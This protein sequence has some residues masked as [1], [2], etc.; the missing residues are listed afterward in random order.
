VTFIGYNEIIAL[1]NAMISIPNHQEIGTAGGLATAGRASIAAVCQTVYNTILSNRLLVT[2]P[3]TIVPAV[4][5]AG[6]H[7][8]SVQALLEALKLNTPA[9]WAA[10]PGLNSEITAVAIEANQY[11][12]AAAY[13]TV[14]LSSLAFTGLSVIM[15]LL[16]PN[17]DN[18]M[19]SKV[20]TTLNQRRKKSNFV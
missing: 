9:A 6:L 5:A 4:T 19:T 14:F 11:A 20:S 13:K 16:S 8:E 12:Y 7:Q 18:L 17:V 1:S 15:S 2:I 3:Q 10:V